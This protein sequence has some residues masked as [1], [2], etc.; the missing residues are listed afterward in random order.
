DVVGA[1]MWPPGSEDLAVP[2]LDE[3]QN[4]PRACV[5]F[6]DAETEILFG[7]APDEV[8]AE[9]ASEIE[10]AARDECDVIVPVGWEHNCYD[11]S[12]D[13]PMLSLPVQGDPGDCVGD[14]GYVSE[15]K[16]GC[17]D[18]PNPYECEMLAA[19]ETGGDAESESDDESGEEP[20]PAGRPTV[21]GAIEWT[22]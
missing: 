2:V 13:G 8:Y 3:D 14:C 4:W 21:E 17:G 11:E 5:C 16:G 9:L 10:Q 20:D 22:R 19:G 1:R 6:N 7:M 15:P 18:D 12:P